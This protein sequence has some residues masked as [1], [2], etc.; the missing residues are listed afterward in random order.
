MDVIC[1]RKGDRTIKKW[2]RVQKLK[3]IFVLALAIVFTNAV[4]SYSNTVKL[5]H[6]QEWVTSSYEVITQVEKIQSTLKDTETAQRNYLITV[7]ADDLKTYL[8]AD[9]QTNRNIQILRKLTANNHQKQQWISLLEPKITSRLDILQ[10]E[11]YLRQNQGFEAVKKRI[12]SDKDNQSSKEIQQLIHDSLEV[13]Q[14]LLHQGMQQS[15][16]NSQKAVVTFFIAA[17]VDLVLVALL[18]DLLWHYIR[19]LQQTELALRQSENRLRAMIDAEPECI[20]LIAKDG[21]LLEINAEGLAMMEVESA[22]VLIGKPIDAVIV[23]EYRAA[24]ANLHKS[25]CQG[26]KGTLEFEIVGFKG[27]RR[28][29]E[30]H[31]VPL[32]NESDGTFIHL[33]LMRDITQQKHAEQKIR[34]QGLLLDVSTEGII[35]RNIHNQILFW[36]Q[37][38]ERLYGWKAEEV[39]GN[40]VLQLLYKDISPQLEDAYLKVINTG[41]WRGELHQLTKEGRVIIVES[42]WILIRD[43]N[44]QTKSILSVNTEITQQKQLEAQLLRSQRLES[45]GTLAGGIVHDL[46]NILSPILMSVQILQ[47]K[48]PDSESQQILQTLENNVKR[49]A[50][51]LKQ[52]LSFARGIEGKRTIVQIQP[53]M[54]EMEQIIAQTFPKSIICQVDIPKNLWDVRGDTT[55]IHQVLIN[56]VVNARDAMPNG[57]ILRIAAENL[58]IGEHSAQ[59]NIDAKVGS[60]IAIVVTDTGMG[61]SLEVQQRIFEPFFTTKEVGKGTG[62]GLST[63]LGIVKNHGGFVNVY[64]QVGRGTQFTVYLPASTF[65]N[66]HLMSQELE[67]VTGNG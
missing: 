25:I 16:A 22:D 41:E 67:S 48:L 30:S 65:R 46:N 44:G 13:E 28:Y 66:T 60:Y 55:Q 20:K 3:A 53:L 40:N 1:R 35:V 64:S 9:Q 39:V 18:Y 36:N 31:A 32:R 43:D 11:I 58:V 24:F 33:A 12:L 59:I 63:A 54:A 37:G 47:K 27:T 19:Q 57:G 38:A 5:I 50:N 45:I 14:N 7:D 2:Y 6:N 21:T 42:R 49:G 23:P 29:M 52:V 62:L 8:A 4:V 26:N 51:L 17:I 34:E 56:L 61:M 15:Q 10:Q